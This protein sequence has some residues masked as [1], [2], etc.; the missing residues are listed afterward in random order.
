MD[1]F[2]VV[3]AAGDLLKV[4]VDSVKIDPG[5]SYGSLNSLLRLFNSSG[6]QVA[7]NDNGTDPDTGIASNDPYL[8]Y[9]VTSAGTYYI[10]VSDSANASYSPNTP[11]GAYSMQSGPYILQ[12]LK[13]VPNLPPTAV[14]DTATTHMGAVLD[15]PVLANDSD[16]NGDPLTITATGVPAN[17]TAQIVT[18]GGIQKIRYTPSAGFVGSNS[19]TYTISDTA[20]ATASSTVTVS[21]TNQAPVAAPESYEAVAGVVRSVTAPGVLA[22]DSDPDGDALTVVLVSGVSNG[23][24][25]LSS[26]GSFTY[27]ATAGFSGTDSFV[28]RVTDGGTQSANTT[29]TLAVYPSN[30]SAYPESYSIGHGKTLSVASPG[31]L[32]ND[33]DFEHQALSA[34]LVTGPAHGSLTL[35]ANGSFAYTPTNGFVGADSF[36]YRAS[37]GVNQSS[38]VTVPIQ[39]TNF[40]PWAVNDYFMVSH[41]RTLVRTA[42]N[43]ILTNDVD[44]E[45]DPLTIT[46]LSGPA[47]GTLSLGPDG[48][49]TFTPAAGMT[50]N[51][52]FVYKISDGFNWSQNATGTI[53]VVNS[54]LW[55]MRTCCPQR[56]ALRC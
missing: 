29:V 20:G 48:A 7:S 46:L 12:V 47:S 38:N 30:V 22:N 6:T 21:V 34:V 14:A 13:E 52:S 51:V 1:L 11:G 31:V 26:S 37:D 17:G 44:V 55:P 23:T 56:Q 49:F 4:D 8:L 25:S 33:W 32:A 15:V 10:G 19:F 27:T 16:P 40:A 41:D 42:A 9:T 50:G 45:D 18:V 28:Y 39:V 5:G 2:S 43:G 3:L 24:L 36:V 35:N 54:A 53:S